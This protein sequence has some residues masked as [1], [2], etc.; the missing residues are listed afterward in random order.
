MRKF[1]EVVL[2]FNDKVLVQEAKVQGVTRVFIGADE[3]NSR[4]VFFIR[5]E[6]VSIYSSSI[7]KLFPNE[8]FLDRDIFEDNLPYKVGFS[9][10]ITREL[11]NKIASS[12]DE[13]LIKYTINTL[14][15]INNKNDVLYVAERLNDVALNMVLSSEHVTH[16][17]GRKIYRA[18]V[19]EDHLF[20]KVLNRLQTSKEDFSEPLKKFLLPYKKCFEKNE[21]AIPLILFLEKKMPS[22]VE[23]F[24]EMLNIKTENNN[25]TSYST[26]LISIKINKEE[27]YQTIKNGIQVDKEK[28]WNAL[29]KVDSF[30][31]KN[32]KSLGINYSLVDG[33]N[34]ST[35]Y[36]NFIVETNEKFSLNPKKVSEVVIQLFELFFDLPKNHKLN[37]LDIKNGNSIVDYHKLSASLAEKEQKVKS[38]SIKI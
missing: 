26:E 17:D 31:K 12:E 38:K 30:F 21:M 20:F 25:L 10:H 9:S 19:L 3:T 33:F 5:P 4:D 24:K 27:L 6:I 14:H 37:E 32:K 15:K 1:N 36:F 35:K 11:L 18:N 7:K 34:N 13:E 22:K 16:K 2:D 28:Y 29:K 23:E 8:E